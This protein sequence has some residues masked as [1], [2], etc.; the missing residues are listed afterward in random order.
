MPLHQYEEHVE[1]IPIDLITIINPRVRNQK[2]FKDII[3]NIAE[4]GL[5]KP[6]TVARKD[7][8]EGVRYDL[9]C[10]Q[11]RLEAYKSLDQTVIPA[12]V[13][14]AETEDCLLQSLVENC[15]RRQHDPLD[16]LHDIGGMKE[17]GYSNTQIAKKT[18]LTLGY[19]KSVVH[20]LEKGEQRLLRAVESGRIPITVAIDIADA[21][22]ADVQSALRTAYEKNL[23]RGRKL[24]NAKQL[25]EQRLRRGKGSPAKRNRKAATTTEIYK[26]YRD[27]AERK[28][29]LIQKA[30]ATKGA[31]TF[32]LEALR[33]LMANEKF[34]TLLRSENLDNLP[35]NLA[36]RIRSLE[37]SG[38]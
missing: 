36:N 28:Q 1:Q 27:D 22:H 13:R 32:V 37:V 12:I 24:M 38:S 23:L 29:I 26:A 9:V 18:G 21:D 14:E 30:D 35:S 5:K 3:D 15:A 31:L 25:I 11:G 17:R 8:L 16:L 2:S 34:A 20:L 19:V 4:L 6:I 10:G 33:S 7:G